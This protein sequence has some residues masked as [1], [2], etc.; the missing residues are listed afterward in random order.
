MFD[1][2]GETSASINSAFL[3][4][5]YIIVPPEKVRAS[6]FSVINGRIYLFANSIVLISRETLKIPSPS[7]DK[8]IVDT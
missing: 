7:I 4:Y 1:T 5:I 2:V 6:Q 8:P 3:L